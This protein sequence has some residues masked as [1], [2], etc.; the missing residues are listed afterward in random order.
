MPICLELGVSVETRRCQS[1]WVSRIVGIGCGGPM[2]MAC[3]RVWW[4]GISLLPWPCHHPGPLVC[5]NPC[6]FPNEHGNKIRRAY[7]DWVLL[8]PFYILRNCKREDIERYCKAKT[9]T[10]GDNCL[11]VHFVRTGAFFSWDAG[12]IFG[13]LFS[14]ETVAFNL[15]QII[16]SI[17]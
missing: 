2:H 7:P 10:H 1:V 6:P 12:L 17:H 3:C 9:H 13:A 15:D 8:L 11:P 16:S 4:E 5:T 14:F